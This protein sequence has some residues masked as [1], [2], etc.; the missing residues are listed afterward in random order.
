[1]K[2]AIVFATLTAKA[3]AALLWGLADVD[4]IPPIR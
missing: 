4:A 3:E 2:A 1:M